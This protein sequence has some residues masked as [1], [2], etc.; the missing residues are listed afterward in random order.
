MR[1]GRKK[2]LFQYF[3]ILRTI[4]REKVEHYFGERLYLFCSRLANA[5]HCAPLAGSQAMHTA[6]PV[7]FG[8]VNHSQSRRTCVRQSFTKRMCVDSASHFGNMRARNPVF[9]SRRQLTP[10]FGRI[11]ISENSSIFRTTIRQTF[12]EFSEMEIRPKLGVSCRLLVFG[13]KRGIKNRGF[14]ALRVGLCF[15]LPLAN[16]YKYKSIITQP[17]DSNASQCCHLMRVFL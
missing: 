14:S 17:T 7:P 3:V 16:F 9:G 5:L 13:P 12:D 15:V 2:R 6:I 4:V 11:S 10:N 8:D 1:D